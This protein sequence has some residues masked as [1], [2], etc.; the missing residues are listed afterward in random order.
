MSLTIALIAAAGSF[1]LPI[2]PGLRTDIAG[3]TLFG[4]ALL[5]QPGVAALTAVIGVVSYRTLWRFR[6]GY[7]A[8]GYGRRWF[9]SLYREGPG[10][11]LYRYPLNAGSAAL[12]VSTASVIF[13]TLTTNESFLTPA[14][15]PAGAGYFLVHSILDSLAVGFQFRANPMRYWW[16]RTRERGLAELGILTIGI[17]GVATYHENA[18]TLPV[19]LIPVAVIYFV[20]SRLTHEIDRVEVAHGELDQANKELEIK[21][22]TRTA[23]LSSSNEQLTDSRRRIVH[24]QEQL[25]KA[26]AL[27]LHGPVQNRILV[28]TEWLRA[29]RHRLESD[30]DASAEYINR[31]V[32]LMEEINQGDLS[33]SVMRLHPSII[34]VSLLAA[35]R[36]LS[37]G[38]KSNYEVNVC[39]DGPDTEGLWQI[40][41][42]EEIRLAIYRVAEEALTNV[43]KHTAATA[44]DVTLS[45]LSSD[46]ATV[47][48]RDNGNGFDPEKATLGFGILS[49]RDYCGAAGGHLDIT[50]E[51][52]RGT[53]ISATFPLSIGDSASRAGEIVELQRTF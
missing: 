52:N 40:G 7:D 22:K 18:W 24:A 38:L 29:A 11:G 28:A 49:M 27:Q 23:D 42:P 36:S 3:A 13:H 32:A 43:Q 35:L 44:V 21:V 17:V 50:S 14:V 53:V 16:K 1:R 25:R 33:A 15:I 8:R 26:V 2:G 47:T 48:I 41:L 10:F 12:S 5:L 45:R 34:R 39:G 31:A 51:V 4:A 19:L 6:Q 20:F 37:A 30:R 9:R 46:R